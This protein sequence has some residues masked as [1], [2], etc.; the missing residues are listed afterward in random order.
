MKLF[1][2][3][4]REQSTQKP[5]EHFNYHTIFPNVGTYER[6]TFYSDNVP[7]AQEL[8][9]CLSAQDWSEFENQQFFREMFEYLHNRQI[10][11]I[12]N[13]RHMGGVI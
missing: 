9:I 6:T 10:Q 2:R 5:E 4:T 11:K 8:V 13:P 1:G 3:K 12:S 7:S